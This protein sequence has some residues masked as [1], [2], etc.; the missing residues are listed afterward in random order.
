MTTC[1]RRAG[2]GPFHSNTDAKLVE[3]SAARTA[4]HCRCCTCKAAVTAAEIG[5]A[6]Q[7]DV[8]ARPAARLNNRWATVRTI[9]SPSGRMVPLVP[10]RERELDDSE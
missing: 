3:T 1:T 2:P 7:L 8:G 5:D 10:G 9:V 6:G 4:W